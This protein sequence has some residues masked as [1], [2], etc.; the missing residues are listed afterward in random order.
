[1]NLKFKR[2][3]LMC[4]LAWVLDLSAADRGPVNLIEGDSSAETEVKSVT[5]GTWGITPSM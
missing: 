2:T 1:M 5:T 4:C 3:I